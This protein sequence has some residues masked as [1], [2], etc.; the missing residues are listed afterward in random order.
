MAELILQSLPYRRDSAHWLRRLADQDFVV[1][2]DSGLATQAEARYDILSA[3]PSAHRLVQNPEQAFSEARELLSQHALTRADYRALQH[4]PFCGGLIG[5]LGYQA[6]RPHPDPARH[7][8]PQTSPC[9]VLGLYEWAIIVDHQQAQTSLFVLP[10]CPPAIRSQVLALIAG[11]EIAG[12]DTAAD[13]TASATG[14]AASFAL[15]QAFTSLMSRQQYA[16]AFQRLQHYIHAG[17][18]YQSNLAVAFGAQFRGAPEQAYLQLRQRS[19]SPFSA[20]IKV[21]E[22]AVLSLSP[23][24]FIS[25]RDARAFTQPIKG[26]RKRL[27]DPQQDQAAIDELMTS[28]KDRAEN[29]MIVDLLRND[30]GRVC[31]TGSVR[32]EALFELHSFS[33]VHHL[34]SSVSGQLP[35]GTS[36]L[37]LLE[38]CFP[39]GSITGAPKIRAMQIIEELESVPRSMYCGSVFYLDFLDRMDSNIC[40]RMLVAQG[41]Q[42]YCWGGSGVVA[43]SDQHQEYQEC[44]DKVSVLMDLPCSPQ[45]NTLA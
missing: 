5:C 28:E 20:F 2:L 43:D 12:A 17:D 11:A 18:C 16:Q 33:H 1:F 6:G 7:P 38:Q 8:A 26:T 14:A 42:L 39:G 23:E 4:L 31:V 10:Q 45:S 19:R 29:L 27:Q 13:D 44:L 9:A 30:L 22:L 25:V 15:T 35:A 3:L 21:G 32:V 34:I 40:I 37:A 36:P 24:R 41:Q